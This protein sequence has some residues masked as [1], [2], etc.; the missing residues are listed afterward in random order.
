MVPRGEVGLVVASIGSGIGAISEDMF[1]VVVFMSIAT[2]LI[3]PP[4][5]VQLFR[6][7]R[8]QAEEVAE[9]EEEGPPLPGM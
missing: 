3:A 6:G 2:T 1:S 7:Y 9:E 8:F 5:L 4:F